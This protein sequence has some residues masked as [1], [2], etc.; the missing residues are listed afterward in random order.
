[1]K[2]GSR[3]TTHQCSADGTDRRLGARVKDLFCWRMIKSHCSHTEG[4][5]N[6]VVMIVVM[7]VV[8]MYL[9]T[10]WP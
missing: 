1:M 10:T 8:M 7:I 3:I 9:C 6:E 5:L 2:P 4:F